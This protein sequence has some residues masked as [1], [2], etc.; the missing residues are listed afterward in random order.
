MKGPDVVARY[1]LLQCI[2]SGGMGQVWRAQHEKHGKIAAVKLILRD[3]SGDRADGINHEFRYLA[4]MQHPNI[5]TVFD[6][7]MCDFSGG[8]SYP[9]VVMNLVVGAVPITEYAASCALDTRERLELFLQVCH[10]VE[11]VHASGVV[12]LDIKPENILVDDAG[13]VFLTDFG[14]ARPVLGWFLEK[15]AGTPPYMSPEHLD[16]D[17]DR[18]DK[19]SD[20]W[21]LGAVLFRLITKAH[22]YD[23]PSD[24]SRSERRSVV[25]GPPRTLASVGPYLKHDAPDLLKSLEAIVH[26]SLDPLPEN[27][28]ADGGELRV[29]VENALTAHPIAR[30]ATAFRRRH[31]R[32]RETIGLAGVVLLSFLLGI[33]ATVPIVQVWPMPIEWL[34]ASMPAPRGSIAEL[35]SFPNVVMIGFGTETARRIAAG[36]SMPGL[37]PDTRQTFRLMHAGMIARLADAGASVITLDVHFTPPAANR[38]ADEKLAAAITA[39]QGAGIPVV[40]GIGSWRMK[41]GKPVMSPVIYGAEPLYGGLTVASV[42]N[43]A[44]VGADLLVTRDGVD[45]IPGLDLVTLAAFTSPSTYHHYELTDDHIRIHH[46]LAPRPDA[47]FGVR[48]TLVR[49]LL[50]RPPRRTEINLNGFQP[51][52]A[53][54]FFATPPAT[55]VSLRRSSI[56]YAEVWAMTSDER[57]QRFGGR[58]A[59]IYDLEQDQFVEGTNILGAHAHAAVTQALL[60]NYETR[61]PAW[62]SY[63]LIGLG[64]VI[65]AGFGVASA[66]RRAARRMGGHAEGVPPPSGRYANLWRRIAL[67]AGAASAAAFILL[68]LTW[69]THY[70]LAVWLYPLPGIFAAVIASTIVL[71]RPPSRFRGFATA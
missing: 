71:V 10:A 30:V 33:L 41:Q 26:K 59:F 27:R 31:P 20:V 66:R 34:G 48:E 58:V 39:A 44:Q 61:A 67:V 4:E 16:G 53:V 40:V 5:V 15:S 23:V 63:P 60:L 57:R 64:A 3:F 62:P 25:R 37:D 42:S 13:H 18:I 2:G 50:T 22:A 65:G 7:G 1:R 49:P 14:L 6:T 35:D 32:T 17:I 54:T 29:A 69:T 55:D 56:S 70:F 9:Y 8:L 43:G 12:H 46:F 21:A 38:E 52:D 11:Y 36:E 47:R 45:A 28:Y 19:P 68:T 51:E 24:A